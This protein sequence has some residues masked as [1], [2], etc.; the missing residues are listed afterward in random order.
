MA[1]YDSLLA[2]KFVPLPQSF[3]EPSA[4][5][6][7]P[8]LLGQWLV[9]HTPQGVCGGPIVETEAYLVDDAASHGFVGE[10]A[11]NRAMYGPPGR[12]YVYLIYGYHFCVNAVCHPA[13]RAE[14]VLIRAIEAELGEAILRVNRPVAETVALTNGPGK[15]CSAMAIDRQLDGAN[16]CEADSALFIAANPDLA[17]FRKKRGPVITTTR[18]GIRRAAHLPL[19]F[20]LGGSAFIS[21]RVRPALPIAIAPPD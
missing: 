16:L 19:R 21:R 8:K 14:A 6:V 2:M 11:R 1:K 12:A 9:R 3:Y 5:I 18:I 20:Y 7:A 17:R 10:T 15:L 4:E 13:G